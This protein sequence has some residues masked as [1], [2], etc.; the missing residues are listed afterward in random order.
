MLLGVNINHKEWQLT[1]TFLLNSV[2]SSSHIVPTPEISVS[3]FSPRIE[4]SFDNGDILSDTEKWRQSAKIKICIVTNLALFV[5][6]LRTNLLFLDSICNL[7]I[8][9]SKTDYYIFHLKYYFDLLKKPSSMGIKAETVTLKWNI[10]GL[11]FFKK[12]VLN[13]FYIINPS[14]QWHTHLSVNSYSSKTCLW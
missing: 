14:I 8:I 10:L 9:K 4:K 13:C 1:W 2:L 5:M 6:R 3:Q 12:L 7:R 11:I